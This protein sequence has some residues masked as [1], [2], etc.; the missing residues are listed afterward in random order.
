MDEAAARLCAA[1]MAMRMGYGD[2]ME[3]KLNY[4]SAPMDEFD[5]LTPALPD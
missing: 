1:N 5:W 3:V 4:T 2:G